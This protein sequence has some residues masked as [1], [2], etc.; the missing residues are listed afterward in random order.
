MAINC[1]AIPANLLESELFGYKRG[2]FTDANRDRPGLLVE[3][4][5][6]TVFLDEVAELPAHLQAKLLRVIQEREV[7][8][9][10]ATKSVPIDIRVVS[11]TNRA[12]QEMLERETFRADLYYR[13]NVVEIMLQPLRER[14][15]DI[16]PIASHLLARA[17]KRSGRNVTQVSP[18]AAK[19]LLG[20][21]WPGNVR[22]LENVIERAVALCAGSCVDVDDLPATL[23]EAPSGGALLGSAAARGLTLAE[24]DREYILQVLDQEEGNKSRTAQRLGLDRKTLYRK[25]DDYGRR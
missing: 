5:G 22:E 19:V 6:G 18:Q 3:S 15:E 21:R 4:N 8:P 9:L 11:A 2:A 16:L 17:V 14:P 20:Y 1:A 25:L 12:L 24:L 7:K 23:L 10:G 13:L